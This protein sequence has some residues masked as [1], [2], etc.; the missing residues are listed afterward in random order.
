MGSN[1]GEDRERP[2][3]SVTVKSFYLG[4]YEVTQ[5]EWT[6][7]MGTT[8]RQQWTMAGISG[9]PTR[10]TGDNY[11]I[12]C[13]SWVEAVEYCNRRSIKE[14]LTPAYRRSGNSIICDFNAGGYRLP[15]EAEWE[16]AATGGN[17][18]P[19]M[20]EYAGGNSAGSVAWYDNNSG[21]SPR[22]VGA[23]QPNSLGLY[24]MSGNVWEWCWDWYGNYS[25]GSQTDPAGAS[26]GSFRVIRGGCWY[27][28][29]RSVR[30]ANRSIYTPSSRST[31]L[32]F[33][34]LRPQM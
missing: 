1:R 7:V 16:Y 21:G 33:R 4:K 10:G 17:K 29:A 23:K 13:V 6:E 12:Y 20:F 32:G 14:K 27:S 3:H 22:P 34:V 18:A 15:T 28:S 2:V 9:N 25:S 8:I 19:M 30:S 26:S 11:P 24:D 31:Y 5:K